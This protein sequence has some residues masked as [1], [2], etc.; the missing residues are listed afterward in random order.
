MNVAKAETGYFWGEN[1]LS[2]IETVF[3]KSPSVSLLNYSL[4]TTFPFSTFIP[5]GQN[6]ISGQISIT[7]A[8][9]S[10]SIPL[11]VRRID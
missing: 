6:S 9:V 1:V 4:P 11:Q 7:F 2:S 5:H 3:Q 10:S 8:L